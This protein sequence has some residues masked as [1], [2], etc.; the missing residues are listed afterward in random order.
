MYAAWGN[1]QTGA[2][3]T[4]DDLTK[5]V[6][7]QIAQPTTTRKELLQRAIAFETIA[8]PLI[9]DSRM[10]EMDI[11]KAYFRTLP[12]ELGKKVHDALR[13]AHGA[14]DT[15]ND[16]FPRVEV[17]ERAAEL[18]MPEWFEAHE[19][20]DPRGIT[21]RT[22]EAEKV[23]ALADSLKTPVDVGDL[24]ARLSKLNV[25]DESYAR[26]HTILVQVQP[27]I[28][29]MFPRP[30]FYQSVQHPPTIST[31]RALAPE[32]TYSTQPANSF[33]RGPVPPQSGAQSD[34][35]FYCFEPGH[36]IG[37]CPELLS[38]E[39]LGYIKREQG[40]ILYKD[41]SWLKR[42]RGQGGL[43]EDTLMRLD[44]EAAERARQFT[45]GANVNQTASAGTY[46]LRSEE[47]NAEV[48][49]NAGGYAILARDVDDYL[50]T[51]ADDEDR[52][53]VE[54]W[55]GIF[56]GGGMDEDSAIRAA[57]VA[58]N[59]KSAQKIRN[60]RENSGPYQGTRG[61][62]E[63]FAAPKP[64]VAVPNP[65]PPKQPAFKPANPP[66]A[67]PV[68]I[69]PQNPIF[70]VQPQPP[71][72]LQRPNPPSDQMEIDATV[73]KMRQPSAMR[74]TTEV[75]EN[76]NVDVVLK[77]L[78]S[79]AV[80]STVTIGELCGVAPGLR[81]GLMEMV[82]AKKVPVEAER[83]V[84]DA[85]VAKG[86]VLRAPLSMRNPSYMMPL[87]ELSVMLGNA[88]VTALLDT[89]SMINVIARDVVEK[90]G[91]PVDE[92]SKMSM[93]GV[94]GDTQTA[95]G[96][97]ENISIPFGR[98]NTRAHFHVFENVP[99]PLILGQPWIR[100]HVISTIENGR[101]FKLMLRDFNDPNIRVSIVV[102]SEERVVVED[103][104]MSAPVLA[105]EGWEQLMAGQSQLTQ[106]EWEMFSENEEIMSE[107][108]SFQ[109]PLADWA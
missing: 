47:R 93:T 56:E 84:S 30:T 67:P 12:V 69:Q 76:T 71:T 74:F 21:Q 4:R 60:A 28:A 59:E 97:C 55:I 109:G 29:N 49:S 19:V 95:L 61:R 15:K 81:K 78:M 53:E 31:T 64:N 86:A 62:R 40:K 103:V 94:H 46:V 90:L 35:C 44:L 5:L 98:L 34:R 68:V 104:G 1:P 100:D 33:T 96:V 80:P 42:Q 6:N 52:A 85:Q 106:E 39:K 99:S 77:K 13:I 57:V 72:I 50:W 88:K 107:S 11:N 14:W 23:A 18:I 82:R 17:K 20:G 79:S 73:K 9:D 41:G 101:T 105:N 70:R 24:V 43:I 3:Y 36:R 54:N 51:A 48:D 16:A 25:N 108:S 27:V 65:A 89:G 22:A 8:Q 32:T 92:R 75:E 66:P 38:H 7:D 37:A 91:L 63:Q 45:S 26:A 102:R 2:R 83:K 10:T 58:V 87:P